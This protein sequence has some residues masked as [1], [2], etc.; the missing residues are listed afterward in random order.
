[1]SFYDYHQ[2]IWEHFR[3]GAGADSHHSTY[4]PVY[5]SFGVVECL[6]IHVLQ[7]PWLRPQDQER[8]L[9]AR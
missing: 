1:M 8:T 9:R 6:E 3:Q 7:R 5:M 2:T 4:L